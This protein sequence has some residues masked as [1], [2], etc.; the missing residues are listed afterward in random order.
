MV[1]DQEIP[2]QLDDLDGNGIY[3]EIVFLV[4]FEPQD[5]R[6]AEITYSEEVVAENRYPARVHAQMWFK[7]NDKTKSYLE[8]KHI[9]TDSVSEVVDNMYSKMMHHGP[10]FE[11]EM[12][13]YRVYFDKK[14]STDLYGKRKHQLE[15]AEGLWYS[16]EVPELVK[17]RQFGDDIIMVG[18]TVSLGALRGWD[19]SLDDPNYELNEPNS[20]KKDPCLLMIEPFAWRQ[21]QIVSK[22]PLRTIVD[23]N[24]KG[25]EYKGRIINVKSRYILYAGTR[26]CEVTHFFE[27]ADEGNKSLSDLEFVT[28]VMKVGIF[29]TD[30][31]HLAG[32]RYFQNKAGLCGSF[33]K[34]WPDGNR[35]LYPCMQ[36]AGLAVNIPNQ[37]VTRLIDRREQILYGIH[38]DRRNRIQYRMA[39][40]APDKEGTDFVS[41]PWT[42]SSWVNWCNLWSRIK[43]IAVRRFLSDYT[44]DND[45][46]VIVH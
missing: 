18:Q 1:D 42:Y 25:W 40:C 38:P 21:A 44:D 13:A 17:N 39:F 34:D 41:E 5:K 22:G 31:T 43:P 32:K 15:L 26:E 35:K 9:P 19:D 2:C 10:A 45:L 8:K 20:K 4:D 37:Y 11:N 28:G 29:N 12:V 27:A 46:G 3:D 33:G 23:M 36:S 6:R 14:Q 30:S 24:V 16:S 7:D